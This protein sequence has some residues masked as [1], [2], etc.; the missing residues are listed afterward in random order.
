MPSKKEA[1]TYNQMLGQV[2]G[3]I[4]TISQPGQDIDHVITQVEQGYELIKAMRERLEVS[5]KKI[6]T[7]L[8]DNS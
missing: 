8:S 7:L 4:Q 6:E 1:V 5:K 3:I 2:E